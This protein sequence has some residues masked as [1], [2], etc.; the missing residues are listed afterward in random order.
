M[1]PGDA[2]D[3]IPEL[4]DTSAGFELPYGYA[5]LD[6]LFDNALSIQLGRVLIDDGWGSSGVDGGT[7]RYG[8]P[9]APILPVNI[10]DRS[11]LALIISCVRSLV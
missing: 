9:V 6:G 10:G 7:V 8:V 1:C 11:R 5:S 2:I 3:V 4:A